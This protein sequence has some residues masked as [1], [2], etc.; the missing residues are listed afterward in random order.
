M[1][2]GIHNKVNFLN[3]PI[4]QVLNT[5]YRHFCFYCLLIYILN[6]C[7]LFLCR[8][9]YVLPSSVHLAFG[10]THSIEILTNVV[11]YCISLSLS[12]AL[13]PLH[14][15]FIKFYSLFGIVV[16]QGLRLVSLYLYRESVR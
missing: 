10:F 6:I 5:C 12:L 7:K 11:I 8:S 15:Q 14:V 13:S 16:N 3:Y 4:L 9:L 2:T 1:E